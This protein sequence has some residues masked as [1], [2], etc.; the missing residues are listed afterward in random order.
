MRLSKTAIFSILGILLLAAI[1]IPL[2]GGSSSPPSDPSSDSI[3]ERSSTLTGFWPSVET[4]TAWIYLSNDHS[5]GELKAQATFASSRVGQFDALLNIDGRQWTNEKI[6]RD[7]HYLS[8]L[9]IRKNHK[10]ID[11]INPQIGG[12]YGITLTCGKAEQSTYTTT[13]A[14]LPTDEYYTKKSN[15]ERAQLNRP[16]ATT[17]ADPEN[18]SVK[19]S[20]PIQE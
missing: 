11:S 16:T 1:C 7:V 20:T 2:I 12:T 8:G 14:C 17:Q 13:F 5:T 6:N 4:A 18:S 15:W 9:V 19:T 3:S 10:T